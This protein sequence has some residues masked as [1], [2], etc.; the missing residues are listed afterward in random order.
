[1]KSGLQ[2]AEALEVADKEHAAAKQAVLDLVSEF[3][4]TPEDR[5]V[6][7]SALTGFDPEVAAIRQA[8]R[9]VDNAEG[10]RADASQAF[11]A[12]VSQ[13]GGQL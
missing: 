10:N 9:A 3:L 8:V 2:L 7:V 1:M 4:D 6:L 11:L 13:N 5:A 12:H